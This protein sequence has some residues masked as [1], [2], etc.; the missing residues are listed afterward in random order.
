M[1]VKISSERQVTLPNRVLNMLGVGPGDDL[2]ILKAPDGFVL[3]P[4]SDDESGLDEFDGAS[5]TDADVP[6]VEIVTVRTGR[7]TSWKRDEIY[8]D[9]GR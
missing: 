4:R 2:E 7:T 9:D 8:G 5:T 1:I 6:M 3:R